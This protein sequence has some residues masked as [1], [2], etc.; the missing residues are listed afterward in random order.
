[1]AEKKKEL[2]SQA[3]SVFCQEMSMMLHAGIT[4]EEALG[5]LS[6]DTKEGSFHDVM[7]S[8]EKR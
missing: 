7:K 1:M 6:E 5:L 3:I 8:M 4:P 2:E